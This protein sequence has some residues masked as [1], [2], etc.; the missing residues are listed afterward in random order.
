MGGVESDVT[1]VLIAIAPD[2]AKREKWK[3]DIA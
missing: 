1:V 2:K 3:R